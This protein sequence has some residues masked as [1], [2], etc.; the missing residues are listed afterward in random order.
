MPVAGIG[1]KITWG[2]V[3]VLAIGYLAGTWLNRQRS[4]KLGEWL[5]G[6][7]GTLGGEPTWK[8][9]G[10]MSSGAQVTISNTVKPFRQIQITYL[11]LTRELLPLWGLELLRG[12]RD[13]L[14]IRANTRFKPGHEIEVLPLHGALRRKL[15]QKSPTPWDWQEGPAGLGLATQGSGNKQLVAKV[16][17]FLDRYGPYVQRLSLRERQPQL[18]LFAHLSG[19]EATPANSFLHAVRDVVSTSKNTAT[20]ANITAKN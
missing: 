1:E 14:V 10:T 12:K 16:R 11:L 13:T 6:G 5:Q 8:W 7:L 9:V 3:I 17:T 15:D 2:V 20:N 18:I 4:K 19:L